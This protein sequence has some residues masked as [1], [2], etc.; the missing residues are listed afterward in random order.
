LGSGVSSCISVCSLSHVHFQFTGLVD[1]NTHFRNLPEQ[2]QVEESYGQLERI[3]RFELP[4]SDVLR[5]D[6]PTTFTYAILR[7]ADLDTDDDLGLGL[8]FYSRVKTHVHAIDVQ[9]VE[10]LVGRIKLEG[11]QYSIV[12]RTGSVPR[13]MYCEDDILDMDDQ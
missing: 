8:R 11:T 4:A 3:L 6:A 13:A 7:P 1:R 10:C 12:D 2:L 9:F 5:L